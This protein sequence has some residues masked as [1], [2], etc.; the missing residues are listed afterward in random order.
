MTRPFLTTTEASVV[1]YLL[2]FIEV[3]LVGCEKSLMFKNYKVIFLS[4]ECSEHYKILIKTG[5][6]KK[7][8]VIPV[9]SFPFANAGKG[10][11]K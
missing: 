4:E 2:N 10:K 9:F 1:H 11:F 7:N 6:F 8:K 5:I 3:R